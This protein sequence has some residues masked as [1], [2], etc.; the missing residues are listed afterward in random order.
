M[1]EQA[2]PADGQAE[3][4]VQQVACLAQRD[5]QV[6][7]AVAG[8]QPRPRPDVGA[9][10]LQVATPLASSCTGAAA[11]NV[12]A[13]AMPFELGLGEVNDNM[14]FKLSGRFE[15]G[16]AAMRTLLGMNVVLDEG[17]LR[18]RLRSK[19]AWMLAM[20]LAAVI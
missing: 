7:A 8:E 3:E 5:A 18:R 17:G 6:G 13:I 9:R 11:M 20:L 16:A 2:C 12:P 14:V 19:D 4:V 10:Q 15:V 1:A